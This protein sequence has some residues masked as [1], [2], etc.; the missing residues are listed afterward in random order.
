MKKTDLVIVGHFI[1]IKW[2]IL[3]PRTH[4][5]EKSFLKYDH[6]VYHWRALEKLN[7]FYKGAIGQK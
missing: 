3:N 6:A 5:T 2:H 4:K 7:K 1:V